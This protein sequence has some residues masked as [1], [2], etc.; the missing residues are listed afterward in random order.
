MD[1][2]I[3]QSPLVDR[4]SVPTHIVLHRSNSTPRGLA[5]IRA[6][7]S[8]EPGPDGAVCELMAGGACIASGKLV[9]R[10]GQWCLQIESMGDMP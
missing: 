10:R 6:T 2:R 3:A 8:F 1:D 5:D 7:G 4:V 9:K